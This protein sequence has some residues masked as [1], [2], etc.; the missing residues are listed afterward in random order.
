MG[1][2]AGLDAAF[3]FV[4]GFVVDDAIVMLENIVRHIEAGEKPMDAAFKGSKEVGFTIKLVVEKLMACLG[5]T[6]VAFLSGTS[7]RMLPSEWVQPDGPMP[8]DEEVARLR[9]AIK[10]FARVEIWCG[11]VYARDWFISENSL[12][13]LKSPA[14]ALR[15]GR[16]DEVQKASKEF[17]TNS[18]GELN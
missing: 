6:L 17:Q 12:L 4:V 16:L 8:N 9:A 5:L 1:A 2:E 3:D 10:S 13:E 18:H 11:T 14:E 15:E 7:N